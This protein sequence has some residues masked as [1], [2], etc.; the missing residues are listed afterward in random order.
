VRDGTALTSPFQ[1]GSLLSYI[2]NATQES[3][4]SGKEPEEAEADLIKKLSKLAEKLS[5]LFENV[6][7]SEIAGV[8]GIDPK[9]AEREWRIIQSLSKGDALAHHLEDSYYASV[10]RACG[11]VARVG[12]SLEDIM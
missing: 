2:V 10:G 3:F 12:H 8:V 4:L 9:F 1:E 11:F 7:A 5:L 6:S